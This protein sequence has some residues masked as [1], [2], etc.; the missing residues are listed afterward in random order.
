MIFLSLDRWVWERIGKKHPIFVIPPPMKNRKI[1]STFS[2]KFTLALAESAH[3]N[4]DLNRHS[5]TTKVGVLKKKTTK[6]DS[7]H[8][9]RLFVNPGKV[10]ESY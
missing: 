10:E 2:Y 5:V 3:K 4:P 7:H 6:A 8:R 1:S 9:C